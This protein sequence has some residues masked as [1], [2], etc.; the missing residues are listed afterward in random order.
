MGCAH[1][2]LRHETALQNGGDSV[3]Q[4]NSRLQLSQAQASPTSKLHL[5]F[6]FRSAHFTRLAVG[7]LA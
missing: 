5:R 1:Y 3:K 2:F 7:G 4:T 6:M